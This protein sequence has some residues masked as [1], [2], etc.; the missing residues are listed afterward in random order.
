VAWRAQPHIE[1]AWIHWS[2]YE[3]AYALL[4]RPAG[5][6]YFTGDWLTHLVA[7]QAGAF[8]SARKVVTQLHQRVLKES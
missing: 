5:R 6:V 4:Q 1:G 7:W 8:E 2:S 3:G